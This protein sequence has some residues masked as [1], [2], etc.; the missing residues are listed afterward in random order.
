MILKKLR[1]IN[2]EAHK[3]FFWGS[4]FFLYE[5]FAL[6]NSIRSNKQYPEDRSKSTS[7]LSSEGI[8]KSGNPRDTY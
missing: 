7:T 8:R 6:L 1:Q 5:E 3:D 4:S 2:R